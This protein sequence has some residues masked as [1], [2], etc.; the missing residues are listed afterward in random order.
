MVK[1]SLLD[2]LW[3]KAELDAGTCNTI[4][5]D[6]FIEVLVSN[7]HNFKYMLMDPTR[8]NT[9]AIDSWLHQMNQAQRE[10]G[11]HAVDAMKTMPATGGARASSSLSPEIPRQ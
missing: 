1:S 11:E 6:K 2:N 7:G 5:K 10:K 3:R 9:T 8:M 4:A